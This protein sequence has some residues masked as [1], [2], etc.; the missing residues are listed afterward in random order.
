MLRLLL[1]AYLLLSFGMLLLVLVMLLL[2]LEQL[3]FELLLL[4]LLLLFELFAVLCDVLRLPRLLLDEGKRVLLHLLQPLLQFDVFHVV[5]ALI[6]HAHNLR[7]VLRQLSFVVAADLA[8]SS[9]ATLAVTHWVLVFEDVQ[10]CNLLSELGFAKFAPR[11]VFISL[12]VSCFDVK[13]IRQVG[14]VLM[15]DYLRLLF[16]LVASDLELAFEA[17]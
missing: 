5:V 10:R 3:L 17:G 7:I 13:I 8:A 11:R 16:V 12:R 4:D 6:A 1:R 2:L 9:R 14:Q 15:R